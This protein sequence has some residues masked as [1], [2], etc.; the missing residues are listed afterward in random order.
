MHVSALP[1]YTTRVDSEAKGQTSSHRTVG[2]YQAAETIY[3]SSCH[4]RREK[5]PGGRKMGDI[6]DQ[7]PDILEDVQQRPNQAEEKGERE[8]VIDESKYM[9]GWKLY[10]LTLG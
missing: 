1:P 7:V 2:I 6:K 4:I 8:E 10:M 3:P 5:K 9:K